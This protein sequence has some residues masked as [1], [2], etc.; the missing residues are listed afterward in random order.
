MDPNNLAAIERLLRRGIAP[1]GFTIELAYELD[2]CDDDDCDSNGGYFL[3]WIPGYHDT[4]VTAA[5]LADTLDW[6]GQ[7]CLKNGE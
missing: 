4:R 6:F 5:T 2:D 3:A 7:L 1:D